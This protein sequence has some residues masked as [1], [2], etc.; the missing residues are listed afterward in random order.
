MSKTSC[1]VID[2]GEE[3]MKDII[4][5]E[6]VENLFITKDGAKAHFVLHCSGLNAANRNNIRSLPICRQC[7]RHKNKTDEKDWRLRNFTEKLEKEKP[8]SKTF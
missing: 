7:L 1:K 2:R 8:P 4:V 6:G 5:E 3:A